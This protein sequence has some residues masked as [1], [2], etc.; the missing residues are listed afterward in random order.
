MDILDLISRGQDCLVSNRNKEKKHQQ[1]KVKGDREG[2]QISLTLNAEMTE[3]N[4]WKK[5]I[6]IHTVLNHIILFLI[7]LVKLYIRN[8]LNF[9]TVGD[10]QNYW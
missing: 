8:K 10:L 6:C 3:L 4:Y 7:K 1:F 2:W 5:H 9:R